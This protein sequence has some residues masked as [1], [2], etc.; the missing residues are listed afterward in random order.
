MTRPPSFE[1][2]AATHHAAAIGKRRKF[3]AGSGALLIAG[4]LAACG[5]TSGLAP[6]EAATPQPAPTRIYWVNNGIHKHAALR[7][8]AHSIGV[9]DLDGKNVNQRLVD[10]IAYPNG[11]TAHGE[12]LYWTD[13][14]DNAIGRSKLDGTDVQKKFITEGAAFPV[15]IS[16]QGRYIYFANNGTFA[17]SRARLDG[18]KVDKEFINVGGAPGMPNGLATDANYIYWSTLTNTIARAK[19]DGT[20]MN[21]KFITDTGVQSETVLSPLPYGLVVSGQYIYWANQA[22]GAVGRAKLDGTE[23]NK[24]FIQGADFPGG[25]A[26]DDQYIYWA[27]NNDTIGRAKL[28]GTEVN[29]KFITGA[30]APAGLALR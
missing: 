19:L 14:F 20:G 15:G 13:T 8:T 22:D 12:Y 24:L 23:A 29:Q 2:S 28:D 26:V 6:T 21:L 4:L 10:G 30:N 11:L 7:A 5:T 25:V 16:V 3:I 9:A 27:N 18:S 17:I 1:A